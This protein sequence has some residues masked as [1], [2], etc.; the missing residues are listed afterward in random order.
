MKISDIIMYIMK[1]MW[2]D[3]KKNLLESFER[4][5]KKRQKS[6]FWMKLH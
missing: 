6:K 4:Y 2:R 3:F 5:T 1:I